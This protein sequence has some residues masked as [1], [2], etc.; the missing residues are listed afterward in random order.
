MSESFFALCI[1]AIAWIR[2]IPTGHMVQASPETYHVQMTSF[3][4]LQ[5]YVKHVYNNTYIYI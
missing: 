2:V 4:C 1:E 3:H 5:S